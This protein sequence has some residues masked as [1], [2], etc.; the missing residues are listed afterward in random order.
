MELACRPDFAAVRQ[1]WDA[2]WRGE[3]RRPLIQLIVPKDGVTVVEKP[4]YLSGAQGDFAP[5]VEQVTGWADS[6]L[7]LGDAVPFYYLEF[8]PDHFSS[9]LGCELSFDPSRPDTSW[10]VHC[11]EDLEQADIR[12]RPD[13]P[14]WQRTVGFIRALRAQLDG[15]ILIAAPTLTANLDALV[16]LMGAEPLMQE[17]AERPAV[18]VRALEAVDAAYGEILEALAA[19]LDMTRWGSITRH[20]M[21]STGRTTVPQCDCSCMFSPA[22]FRRFALPALRKEMARLDAVEYH[23]D[24]SGAIKHLESLCGIDRLGV[25]Q[26]VPGAGDGA[27]RDWSE[28][29][30][31]IDALGKGQFMGGDLSRVERL[32][33]TYRSRQLFFHISARDR[34]EAESVV[35]AV[36]RLEL[37]TK[38]G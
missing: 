38:P 30:D 3:A 36:E 7:F 32:W 31:R 11:V 15:R 14:W 19:E 20:G 2:F 16:A 35:A 8:G 10:A 21:Y 18:V 1:R 5:V 37:V 25:I 22:M 24:G 4:R 12:F 13:G 26:W 28:L 17:L 33:C 23:L 34:V 6:H 9:L 29:H 27:K